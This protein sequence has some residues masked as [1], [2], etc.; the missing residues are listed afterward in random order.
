MKKIKLKFDDVFNGL[1]AQSKTPTSNIRDFLNKANHSSML[2]VFKKFE[3]S[4]NF[5]KIRTVSFHELYRV[6][7][8]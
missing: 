5:K 6:S 2:R 1:E 8:I 4:N 3:V 7:N